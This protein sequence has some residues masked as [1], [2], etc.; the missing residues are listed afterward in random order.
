MVSEKEVHYLSVQY[1]YNLFANN[2]VKAEHVL[3]GQ[4]YAEA[5]NRFLE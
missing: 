5:E 1:Y 2:L 3:G 4:D